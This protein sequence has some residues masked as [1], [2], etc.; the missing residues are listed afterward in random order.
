MVQINQGAVNG[1][2]APQFGDVTSIPIQLENGL[3]VPI[4]LYMLEADGEHSGWDAAGRLSAGQ[5]GL[6]L[7][8]AEGVGLTNWHLGEFVLVLAKDSG[9]FVTAYPLP[10]TK[11]TQASLTVTSIDATMLV[12]PN[13]IG[14]P[15][16][17]DPALGVVIPADGTRVL[18]GCGMAPNGN[19][20]TREQFW[21]RCS[22]SYCLAPRETRTISTTVSNGMDVT[23]S[24]QRTVA[25]SLGISVSGGW[26]P[27]SASLSASLSR[28]STSFHQVTVSTQ[29]TAFEEQQVSNTDPLHSA[30]VLV[31]Q[32][33][34][35][36]TIFDASH[37][38]LAAVLTGQR[39]TISSNVIDPGV[40]PDWSSSAA[41]VTPSRSVVRATRVSPKSS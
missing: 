27:V 22:T 12:A 25:A 30:M 39:P 33:M 14:S 2:L 9:A 36:L 10:T 17:P 35:V 20:V 21:Q 11:P 29:T 28:S 26:G 37:R 1:A 23:T 15:P 24:E 38:P 6:T 7:A 3:P 16:V 13:E 40:G 41:A 32:L 34:D 19:L 4:T 5:P 8:P 31:W 18:V